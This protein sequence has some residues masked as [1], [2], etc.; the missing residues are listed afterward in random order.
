MGT[1]AATILLVDEHVETRSL[2]RSALQ[3]EGFASIE[4]ESRDAISTAIKR[5]SVSLIT[6]EVGI[7]DACGLELIREIRSQLNVPT[8]IITSRSAPIDRLE[9]L[10]NGAD[11]YVTRPFHARELILRIRSLLRRYARPFGDSI[12][13]PDVFPF[14]DC[15]L[16]IHRRELRRKDD[17]V[18]IELTQ[19]EF[20][21]LE[22]FL[23]HPARVLS[24]DEINQALRGHEWSP[25]DRTID[26]HISR[27]RRKLEPGGDESQLIKSVRGIGYVFCG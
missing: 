21:L 11:D 13:Q 1:S 23:R 14:Q 12:A 10:E 3:A 6:L 9:L 8:L 18:V 7:G 4:L 27:L 2:V 19:I 17:G 15:I 25:T 26:G 16:D 24:R 5:H 20:K 22:L